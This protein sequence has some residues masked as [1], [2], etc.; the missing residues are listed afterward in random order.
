MTSTNTGASGSCPK[1]PTRRI[2]GGV[3]GIRHEASATDAGHPALLRS[4]TAFERTEGNTRVAP[5]STM[6]APVESSISM[7]KVDVSFQLPA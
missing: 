1:S 6:P 3:N 4:R 5:N 2:G 7:M